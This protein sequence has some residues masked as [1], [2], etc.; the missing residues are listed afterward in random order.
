MEEGPE[1]TPETNVRGKGVEEAEKAP[2][3]AEPALKKPPSAAHLPGAAKPVRPAP[4]RAAEPSDASSAPGPVAKKPA[5]AAP[6]KAQPAQTGPDPEAKTIPAGGISRMSVK[7][8]R[9]MAATASGLATQR[10]VT[11]NT[12][13]RCAP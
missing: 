13:M 3:P 6:A 10:G 12:R 9:E 2:A 4:K 7:D 11:H 8:K 5:K 1:Q